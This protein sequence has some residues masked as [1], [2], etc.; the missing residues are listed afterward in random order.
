MIH[1]LEPL[2]L[3][4]GVRLAVLVTQ[5][6]VPVAMRGRVGLNGKERQSDRR[7]SIDEDIDSLS[8]L[9]T[10]WY[11]EL[12]RAGGLL[13]WNTQ[14]RAVLRAARGTIVMLGAPGAVLLVVLETGASPEELKLPMEG[15]VARMHRVLRNMSRPNEPQNTGPGGALPQRDAVPGS[16]TA[17]NHPHVSPGEVG[18][19]G[20]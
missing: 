1:I 20:S 12:G 3:I 7:Q 5:D 2:A 4:P 18:Q 10:N 19:I 14:R 13:S 8:G 16:D 6:G 11:D 9:A 15:A 17:D